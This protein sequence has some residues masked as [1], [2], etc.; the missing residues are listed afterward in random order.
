M[1]VEVDQPRTGTP[2]GRRRPARRPDDTRAATP[3]PPRLPGRR[4]PRWI[5]LGVVAICLGGLL[6]YAVYARVSTETRVLA[7]STTVYRGQ[8]VQSSDLTSVVLHGD[9]PGPTVRLADEASVVGRR[10][11]PQ[12]VYL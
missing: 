5:A 2:P 12:R 4:S 9:P 1:S 11:G 3:A 6:A 8:V 10:A 7:L